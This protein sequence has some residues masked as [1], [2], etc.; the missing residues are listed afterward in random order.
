MTSIM[1]NVNEINILIKNKNALI[2]V[3]NKEIQWNDY[4]FVDS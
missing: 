1:I 3:K 2:L 4:R